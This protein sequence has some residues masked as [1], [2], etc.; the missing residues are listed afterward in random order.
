MPVF[1][2]SVMDQL[3]AR[4]LSMD[5]DPQQRT[6][7]E[8]I[9]LQYVHFFIPSNA[10]GEYRLVKLYRRWSG[11]NIL[12]SPTLVMYCLDDDIEDSS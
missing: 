8:A 7:S 11:V 4:L 9:P 10:A 3:T 12:N 1:I 6:P 5:I 2:F